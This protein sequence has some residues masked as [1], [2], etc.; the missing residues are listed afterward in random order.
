M[1]LVG[2]LLVGMGPIIV[3]WGILDGRSGHG[4]RETA[5]AVEVGS[6]LASAALRWCC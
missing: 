2:L 4:L 5:F 3:G 6:C 1:V